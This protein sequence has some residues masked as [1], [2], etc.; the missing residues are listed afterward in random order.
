VPPR[1]RRPLVGIG[2]RA[3]AF[4]AIVAN[5]AALDVLEVTAEHYVYGSRRVRAMIEELAR[6]IPIVA[7][8]VSLSIGTASAPDPAFLEQ[9][10]AF[11]R[12]VRAPWYSEHLAFTRTP[13]RDLAQL[14]PLARTAD[15]LAVVLENLAFVQAE[16][17][18]PL[19]LENVSYYFEHAESEMSE[20]EFLLAVLRG[21]G[22]TV[23]LD[24]ENLRIN[25]ANHGYDPRGFIDA[26]PAGSVRAVHVAG[27]TFAHG[28]HLDSH[29]RPVSAQTFALLDAALRAQQPEAV[30]IERDREV[31][32]IADVLADVRGV[33][34]VVRQVCA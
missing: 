32:D 15:M 2:F 6:R 21:G 25:A 17:A 23:L 13:S 33:R 29:D 14:M 7:H 8:G 18:L 19:A 1:D 3:E 20:C 9:V 28:L 31:D 26:L 27:G 22:G 30:I 4:D 12:A 10:G 24:V 5:L 11:L 34:A 16:L